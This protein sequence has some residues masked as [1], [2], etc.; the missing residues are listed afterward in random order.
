MNEFFTL[1]DWCELGL[2]APECLLSEA[3]DRMSEDGIYKDDFPD[4]ESDYIIR[5]L[6]KAPWPIKSKV[7]K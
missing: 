6:E 3:M 1:T 4:R 7:S 2:D 5:I